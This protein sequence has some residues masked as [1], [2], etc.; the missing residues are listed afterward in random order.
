MDALPSQMLRC[1]PLSCT[2]QVAVCHHWTQGWAR[3]TGQRLG[4]LIT[5][6]SVCEYVRYLT[7]KEVCQPN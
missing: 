7:E 3:S 5:Q 2:R 1:V 6:G 4:C